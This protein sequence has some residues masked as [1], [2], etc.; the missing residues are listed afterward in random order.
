MMGSAAVILGR[1]EE[2]TNPNRTGEGQARRE[3]GVG[4]FHS[5]A[6]LGQGTTAGNGVADERSVRNRAEH[7]TRQRKSPVV[8]AVL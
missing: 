1:E 7:R 2:G 6:K 5:D 8:G 3:E 4:N